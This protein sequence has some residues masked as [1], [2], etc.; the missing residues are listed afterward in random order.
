[1]IV[2][3]VLVGGCILL[4]G[5]GAWFG[6]MG[7]NMVKPL[8]GCEVTFEALHESI[9]EYAEEHKGKLPSAEKWQDEMKPYLAK[10]LGAQVKKV[11]EEGVGWIMKVM[12]VEKDWGC[13]YPNSEKMTGI[14][15][16]SAL[17]GKKV[18]D[19]ESKSTTVILFEIKSPQK[20]ATQKFERLNPDESPKIGDDARGWYEVTWE[21]SSSTGNVNMNF[22]TRNRRRSSNT[23]NSPSD[24][25]TSEGF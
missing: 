4:V 14:A 15:F 7:I 17:S 19:I 3:A 2:L 23:S 22:G 21:G 12:D 6:M 16:N 11:N 24:S 13:Y 18:D 25:G 20:N 5:M 8:V 9:K 1:M 10:N